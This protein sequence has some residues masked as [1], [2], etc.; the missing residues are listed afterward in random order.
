LTSRVFF[1]VNVLIVFLV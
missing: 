1:I